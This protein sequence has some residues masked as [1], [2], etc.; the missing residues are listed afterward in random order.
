M[1]YVNQFDTHEFFLLYTEKQ[2][3]FKDTERTLVLKIRSVLWAM[4]RYPWVEA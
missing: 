1:F 4:L 3:L 2:M